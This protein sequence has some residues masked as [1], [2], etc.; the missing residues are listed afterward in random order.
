MLKK[1]II[2]S[3]CTDV[4]CEEIINNTIEEYAD[5]EIEFEMLIENTVSVIYGKQSTLYTLMIRIEEG[6]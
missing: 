1:V 3:N 5:K 6:E 2:R 4:D